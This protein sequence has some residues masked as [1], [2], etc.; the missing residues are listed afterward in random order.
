MWDLLIEGFTV[1][2]APKMLLMVA[3]AVILGTV[4]GALPGVSA[5]MAVALGL[6]ITYTMEPIPAIV[7][8]VAI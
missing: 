4:F 6:T 8:L 1:V 3:L 2:F 5:T 7:F